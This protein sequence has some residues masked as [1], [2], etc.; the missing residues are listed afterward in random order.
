MFGGILLQFLGFSTS[1]WSMA[2]ML[3][4][5]LFI[6]LT[7]VKADLGKAK[8]K[9]TTRDLFSKTREINY[10]S[11]ARVFLFASRDV[12]F[13]VGVP[14]FLYDQFDWS[15][16]QVG[17]FMAAWL[18]GYGIV[19]ATVPKFFSGEIGTRIGVNAAKYW[20]LILAIVSLGI[21]I[22]VSPDLFKFSENRDIT[23]VILM[24]GLFIFGIVFAVNSSIHSF[25]IVAYSDR[26]KVALNV[27][28][29]YM[30]NSL[31]RLVGTLLSGLVFQ[32][33]GLAA[34]LFVTA[35]LVCL[36][37]LLTWPLGRKASL[38][39]QAARLKLE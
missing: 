5:I 27:G 17:T 14:V 22:G 24:G 33:F 28:F 2:A 10:L 9:I 13:V 11:G 31:G 18:I 30:A 34:C 19:Q 20:G 7:T 12:W 37:V 35:S 6:T 15:F 1:L 21:G 25:L 38:T 16:D 36:A 26:D 4:L 3:T 39:N 8:Q 29:Y 23:S 32:Y